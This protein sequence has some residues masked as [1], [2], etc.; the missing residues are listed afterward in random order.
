MDPGT[1]SKATVSNETDFVALPAGAKIGRYEVVAVLGQGGFGIT[2][3][4]R[5]IQL[6]R[7]VAIKEYLPTSLAVRKDGSTV[8]P[9][10]TKV[11]ED[12]TWGRERFVAEG[13]TMATLHDAP[14][15]VKV[16]DFLEINGTAYIVMEMLK[17]DTL[18]GHLKK[19]GRMDPEAIDQI[20]WPLL[21]G[22]EQVHNAGFLHRDIKPANILLNAKGH[23]TLIDFGASRAAMVGRTVAMTAI[24]TPG[25]AAA[26][27]FTS[28]KQG[29]WTDIYGLAATL[30]HAITGA[31]PPSAFDRMLDDE[32]EPIART[33]PP[34]FAPGLLAGIDAGLA[35]RASDRPQSIAGW[36]AILSLAQGQSA[37]ATALMSGRGAEADA[38]IVATAGRRAGPPT[39]RVEAPPV[40]PA[41]A[42]SPPT[43]SPPTQSPPA[44]P[45]GGAAA[46]PAPE[47]GPSI[48]APSPRG[49]APRSRGLVY[50]GAAALALA[51]LG[52]GGYFALAPKTPSQNSLQDLKVEDLERVLAERRAADAAAAEKK[53]MEEEAARKAAADTAAKQAADAELEKARQDRER[54]EAQLA[55]MKAEMD[56]RRRAEA[57]QRQQSEAAARVAAEEEA[58]RKAE[59]EMAALRQ[60]EED[61]KKKAAAEAESKRQADEALAKAQAARAAADAD[62][63]AKADAEAKRKADADAKQVAEAQARDQAAAAK[64]QADADA[65]AKADAEAKAKADAEADKKAAEAAETALRLTPLDRQH[66]QVALTALGFDTRGS[67]GAFGPR[68][69]EAIAAYQKSRNEPATSFLTAAQNQALLRDASPAVAKFDADQRKIED[70]KKKAEEEAKRKADE[71]AKAKAAAAVAPAPA[72]PPPAAAPSPAAPQAVP[73]PAASQSA[74][75]AAGA[76]SRWFGTA[77]CERWGGTLGLNV[78]MAGGKGTASASG[79]NDSS[80]TITIS[81]NSY[82]GSIVSYNKNHSKELTGRFS[83]TISG[84]QISTQVVIRADF[85]NQDGPNEMMCTV[86][87]A[88]AN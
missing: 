70:D 78:V 47:S 39:A 63:K 65:K 28:A 21:D 14:G 54:A 53:R 12:F 61:A 27:Q 48:A 62:A 57:G 71:D 82:S 59:A 8:L 2:Y 74:P 15:I 40:Q 79:R 43:Q 73:P 31:P 77:H 80:A 18:E 19:H 29:P 7:E 76:I 87:L 44:Q 60:A 72:P 10:S 22:L 13:R 3:R 20:V 88:G 55:Q 42:P 81:G 24:F 83:G 35:V 26:E 30:Y 9:R 33:A 56:V 46:A 52:G 84:N 85:K 32:Y 50:G 11:A 4:A 41:P 68:S 37:D 58:A 75:S 45:S 51:L 69:R 86:Q 49:S 38:T 64:A 17:G 1:D 16:F 5:D 6:G 25:Y 34:G 66:V 36:R 23:P 67:D